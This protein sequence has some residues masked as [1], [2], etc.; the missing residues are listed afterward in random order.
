MGLSIY[1]IR[2]WY[3]MLTGKSI[4][5]VKQDMGKCFVPGKLEGYFN[6]MTEKVTKDPETLEKKTIPMTTDEIAGVVYFPVAI[7][8]YGLG[9][10]D[11]YIMTKEEKYL[12]QFWKCVE[13]AV[14]KQEK[15]G[16]WN[17]FGFVYPDAPYGSM[18]QGEG[19]SLL[20][21]AYKL[22]GDSQYIEKAK[23]AIDFML[24][25]VE[26][27]G[28]SQYKG[29][30]ILFCEFTNKPIVLNGWIF[31]LY[32]LYDLT[33]ISKSQK[34][35]EILDKAVKSLIKYLDEFDNGYWSMYDMEGKIT[36]P[37]YHNLHIAQLEALYLT[38]DNM[39]FKEIQQR[40][41]NYRGK[42]IN[43]RRAFIKKALQK[44]ID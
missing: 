41:E 32:G 3:K 34:Y 5:H 33:L 26:Q 18:C 9:A 22:T 43:R 19:A 31:S 27:G 12:N 6:N 4:M 7:F 40:F 28:T 35:K 21:R 16:A 37:F 30:D 44:I 1:N 39:K 36:S 25:P 38:F 8:Q 42:R 23:N 17:N 29:E 24:K 2:K 15:T 11:L 13:F 10:F 14:D 20:L